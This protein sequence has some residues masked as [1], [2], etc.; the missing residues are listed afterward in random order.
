[1]DLVRFEHNSVLKRN[2]GGAIYIASLYDHDTARER[3]SEREHQR[4]RTWVDTLVHGDT[5]LFFIGFLLAFVLF[6]GR[7]FFCASFCR[8]NIVT[9]TRVHCVNNSAPTGNGGCMMVY[10]PSAFSAGG[11]TGVQLLA[12]PDGSGSYLAHNSAKNGGAIAVFNTQLK[13]EYADFVS[14]RALL[15]GGTVQADDGSFVIM[16]FCNFRDSVVGGRLPADVPPATR[17]GGT[18]SAISGHLTL[19][20]C[21]IDGS[22]VLP[23]GG[24]AACASYYQEESAST[25]DYRG[26]VVAVGETVLDSLSNIVTNARACSGAYLY[27]SGHTTCQSYFDELYG[28]HA[29]A[30]SGMVVIGSQLFRS[31]STTAA[32]CRAERAAGLY[33]ISA[34]LEVYVSDSGFSNV[35]VAHGESVKSKQQNGQQK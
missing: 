14:H 23:P 24:M 11:V 31:Y 28:L 8:L 3:A 15:S 26:G 4:A 21:V 27:F 13:V 22:T 12:G 33:A 2:A 32:N 19:D 35:S 10:A 17:Q 9:M 18:I 29:Y 5:R 25:S 34:S 6:L 7:L 16:S 1:M 30:A 20:A